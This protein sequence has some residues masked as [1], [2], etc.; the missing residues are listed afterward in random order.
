MKQL[1]LIIG[2]PGSGKTTD[3]EHIAARHQETITHYSTGDMLRDE[4]ARNSEQGK[5]ID[6]FISQGRIVPIEIAMKTIVNAIKTAP[7]PVIL[8][9]GYP[10]SIEQME[11]LENF[12]ETDNSITL[13]SVIEVEVSQTVAYERVVG[14]ARGADDERNVFERRM[15]IYTEPL[16][17]IESFYTKKKLLHRINGERSIDAV[18]DDMDA[19]IQS[20]I[21]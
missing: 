16:A 17:A 11:A 8:L 19:F 21:N 15:K 4:V 12:L 10:R 13:V 6:S 1:I 7:T 14:R 2:A 3:A 18:V 5:I 9:D 20:Q